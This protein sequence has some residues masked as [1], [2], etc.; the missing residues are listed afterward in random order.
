ML[1]YAGGGEIEIARAALPQ[2]GVRIVATDSGPGIPDIPT[3]EREG[4]TTGN[5]LGLGLSVVRKAMD[6]IAIDSIVGRGTTV[7]A[8]KWLKDAYRQLSR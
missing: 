7:I 8:E 2:R 6:T 5:G 4:Y 1:V 3:A